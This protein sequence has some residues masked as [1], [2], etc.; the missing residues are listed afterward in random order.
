MIS[1]IERTRAGEAD[2]RKF[3][4]YERTYDYCPLS[5]SLALSLSIFLVFFFFSLSFLCFSPS[6]SL[7][8][9]LAVSLSSLS[10]SFCF[11]LS[12]TCS[13]SRSSKVSRLFLFSFSVC[14]FHPCL[15]FLSLSPSQFLIALVRKACLFLVTSPCPTL[16]VSAPVFF[17][18]LS[19]SSGMRAQSDAATAVV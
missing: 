16:V 3:H 6:L 9:S 19:L 14:L 7:S 15:S 11:S 18:S 10:V 12:F 17:P 1:Q 8:L 4:P 5:L 13:S 2:G